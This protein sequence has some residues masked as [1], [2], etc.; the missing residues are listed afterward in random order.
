M[1][2]DV[3]QSIS[4]IAVF[5]IIALLMSMIVFLLMT[6]RVFR[7]DRGELERIKRLPLDPAAPLSA[8]VEDSDDERG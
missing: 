8:A 4:G 6:F 2:S 7:L 1:I 3:L 5:P